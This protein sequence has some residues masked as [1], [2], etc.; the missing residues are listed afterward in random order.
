MSDILTSLSVLWIAPWR[1]E[2]SGVLWCLWLGVVLAPVYAYIRRR[3]LGQALTALKE[4]GASSPETAKTASELGLTG[5]VARSLGK[6]D[7]LARREGDAF[8]LPEEANKKAEAVIRVAPAAWWILPLVAL[9]AYGVL[10]AAWY[11]IPLF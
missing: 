11:I 3:T 7:R 5:L 4:A 10:V 1:D 8:Y 2:L 9:G 6:K